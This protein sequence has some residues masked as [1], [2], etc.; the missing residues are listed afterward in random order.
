M[1]VVRWPGASDADLTKVVVHISIDLAMDVA[2][3]RAIDPESY[4]I[5]P[6][7]G[8][9]DWITRKTL[10]DLLE[11][12][13]EPDGWQESYATMPGEDEDTP[14]V[15]AMPPVRLADEGIISLS[16]R[17]TSNGYEI[18]AYS[19]MERDHAIKLL[20]SALQQV[21]MYGLTQVEDGD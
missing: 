21:R 11:L 6:R 13:F 10:A 14:P 12:G 9:A 1:A 18:Q 3:S 7:T 20:E 16:G 5:I 8:V 17:W 15:A 4:P 19:D 2:A